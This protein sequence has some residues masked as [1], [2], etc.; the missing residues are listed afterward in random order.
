MANQTNQPNKPMNR[1][2]FEAIIIAKAWKDPA[3]RKRLLADPKKVMQEE[4][5]AVYPN[6]KLPNDL[7]IKVVEETDK[8]L[9]IVLPVNPSGAGK[10]A[11]SDEDL[12]AVAGGTIAVVVAVALT[13]VA[14][15]NTGVQT[16]VGANVNAGVNV[17][18]GYNVSIAANSTT[19]K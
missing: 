19:V 1:N 4:L 5:T 12:D 8:E 11:L 16:N 15:I 7:K 3:F 14:T 2:E 10:G 9:T 13:V 6:A 17:N 18:T